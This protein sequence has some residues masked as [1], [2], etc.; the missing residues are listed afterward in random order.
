MDLDTQFAAG[1]RPIEGSVIIG[2]V[3]EV[4]KG[5]DNYRESFY[6]IVTVKQD[7]DEETAI[8][9]FHAVLKNRILELQPNIGEKI[10][11]KCLGKK[12]N[13]NNPRNSTM[14]Y[15][16]KVEGRGVTNP[17]S[18]MS[19]RE[20]KPISAKTPNVDLHDRETEEET[21]PDDI[22]F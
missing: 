2:V 11:V 1:W 15:T 9:C 12:P 16:V 8:H 21:D 3:T 7:N 19:G 18:G 20:R 14:I 17:Y 22:P 4:N 10:G 6:P 5:W 13:K